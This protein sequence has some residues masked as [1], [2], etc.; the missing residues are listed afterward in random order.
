MKTA[1]KFLNKS[2]EEIVSQYWRNFRIKQGFIIL[3]LMLYFI[4]SV[5][6][7]WWNNSRFLDL[8]FQVLILIMLTFPISI[9]ISWDFMSLNAIM[10][11]NC[12][13]VTYSQVMRLLGKKRNRKRTTRTIQINEAFG[14]MWAG[15]FS[16]A[17]A[18][19]ESLAI[20]ENNTANQLNLLHIRFNCYLK[21]ENQEAAFHI[22][23]E[24]KTLV[25]AVTKPAL[26]KRGK[27]VLDLMADS[28][29]MRQGN[30][31]TFRRMEEA[32]AAKY[33]TNIQRVASAL[34]LAK[35]D[36]AEGE[37]QNARNRLEYVIRSGRALYT[38]KEAR[39]LLA[40]LDG[41]V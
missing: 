19:A 13:P 24:A 40:D 3:I 27:E 14:L 36:I 29:A 35:A 7:I 37:P 15:Q 11:Q 21:L 26:Q 39:Q 16:E 33:R 22:Q 6:G 8:L 20:S 38:V 1:E 4:G 23:Q 18:L 31:E 12:D 2:P 30:Y 34:N 25:S 17:L 28:I 9:W 41:C 10:S 5:W 32:R